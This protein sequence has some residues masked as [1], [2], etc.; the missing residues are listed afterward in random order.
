MPEFTCTNAIVLSTKPLGENTYIIS[1]FTPENGRYLGVL[2]KKH[3]PEIGT[4]CQVI[5]KARLS[6]QLGTFYLEEIKSYAPL[7]LDD[8]PRL[9]VLSNL[10]ATLDK[11]LPERQSYSELH[12]KTLAFLSTLNNTNFY[13]A[14]THFEVDLL[15]ALGFALD[16]S[17][18]AGGGDKNDL[19][20]ISPKTGRAVSREK[21]KPYHDKLL[22]LPRFLWKKDIATIDDLADGLALT[23]HFLSN[24]LGSLPITRT[25]ILADLQRRRDQEEH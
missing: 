19:A 18:C 7:L 1:L 2:K 12:A 6:E 17:S 9:N 4:L 20:Y 25:R 16:M 24:Y 15:E 21:G 22:K 11:A 10:C 8:M 13:A 3:P 14:Y 5:W 23:G